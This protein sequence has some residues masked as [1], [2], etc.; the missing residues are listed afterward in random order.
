MAQ[1]SIPMSNKVGYSMFWNSM[2]DRKI[3]FS[4]SLKE[5]IFL[6]RFI[7][8]IFDDDVSRKILK[9]QNFNKFNMRGNF[10]KY[11][12]PLKSVILNKGD[13]IKYISKVNK[14]EMYRSKVWILKY[15][16]WLII[17][18]FLYLPFFNKYKKKIKKKKRISSNI[19]TNQAYRI[20]KKIDFKLKFSYDFFNTKFQI[21]YF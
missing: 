3:N 21:N 14:I 6:D 5:G 19:N 13:F 4:R 15:Q 8:L 1:I 7:P 17:F 11:D 16:K 18:F 12:L 20:Y 10:L 9:T 2:W